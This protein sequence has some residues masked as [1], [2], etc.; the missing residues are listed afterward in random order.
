VTGA[1]V[2]GTVVPGDQRG[3]L[4]GFP[5]TNLTLTDEAEIGDGVWAGWVH[6]ATGEKHLTTVSVGRR[7]TFY[8]SDPVRLLEAHLPDATVDL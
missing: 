8:R 4:L 7:P 1:V 5:P 6:R 3:R 2:R